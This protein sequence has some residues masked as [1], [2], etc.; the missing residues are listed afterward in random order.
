MRLS[1]LSLLP[2]KKPRCE[3]CKY[4][5]WCTQLGS[6]II[7]LELTS[8]QDIQP[9]NWGESIQK[10]PMKTMMA[11]LVA[12]GELQRMEIRDRS[13]KVGSPLPQYSGELVTFKHTP[14]IIH[15][16]FGGSLSQICSF[17]LIC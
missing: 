4:P 13:R 3:N 6:E 12:D 5:V 15:Q 14:T 17:H 16:F 9:H 7:S 1:V 2:L 11:V 8:K 10:L